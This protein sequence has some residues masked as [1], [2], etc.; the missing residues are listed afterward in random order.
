[1][2]CLFGAFL[3]M[4]AAQSLQADQ[5]ALALRQSTK[6]TGR[7]RIVFAE[8][9][10]VFTIQF[11]MFAYCFVIFILYYTFHLESGG[12]CCCRSVCSGASQE[13]PGDISR[14]PATG[15]WSAEGL[16]VGSSLL[17]SFLAGLMFGNMKDIIAHYAPILNK[18]NPAALISDAFTAYRSMRIRRGIWKICC[19]SH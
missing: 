7:S 4:N 11:A 9:L 6:P 12:G 2:A 14:K 3:G 8:M 5:T 16:L 13:W 10:A 18:V 17:M 19:C 1:M 15:S